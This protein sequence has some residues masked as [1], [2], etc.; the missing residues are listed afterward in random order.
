MDIIKVPPFLV[1]I[2]TVHGKLTEKSVVSLRLQI[3]TRRGIMPGKGELR[4]LKNGALY[5]LVKD[6]IP[7]KGEKQKY[8][9]YGEGTKVIPPILL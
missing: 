7:K 1:V 6:N 9:S 5:L 2:R 8:L 3:K 4:I